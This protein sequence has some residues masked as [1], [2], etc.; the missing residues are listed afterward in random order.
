VNL[1]TGAG[2]KLRFIVLIDDCRYLR[3]RVLGGSKLDVLAHLGRAARWLWDCSGVMIS[4]DTHAE[5]VAVP[6]QV[7]TGSDR[8][9][10]SL[11]G[12]RQWV[13]SQLL[14]WDLNLTDANTLGE[15]LSKRHIL[16]CGRPL[17]SA[18]WWAETA[19][20][21]TGIAHQQQLSG[22]E[23]MQMEGN[24]PAGRV[25]K[26]ERVDRGQNVRAKDMESPNSWR[27]MIGFIERKLLCLTA[28]TKDLNPAQAAAIVCSR[29]SLDVNPYSQLARDLVGSH[30]AHL[31]F[32]DFEK[33]LS[34]I[35]YLPEAPLAHG[36][37]HLW[38]PNWR[39]DQQDHLA[40][41]VREI[42]KLVQIREVQPGERV[43]VAAAQIVVLDA[44]DEVS[45][46]V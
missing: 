1:V 27:R 8:A 15:V 19:G 39:T 7:M 2:R 26:A 42:N 17:W 28:P 29:V 6:V 33:G 11:Y 45:E 46:C 35:S 22:S 30:M 34:V 13:F 18:K 10:L 32:Y 5:V 12:H 41:S 43:E 38:R 36:A 40:A 21:L 37:R 23:P 24:Q 31:D 25:G 44:L 20:V 3:R 16:N 9:H 14:S 4:V